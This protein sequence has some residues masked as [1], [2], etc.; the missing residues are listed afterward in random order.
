MPSTRKLP[1]VPIEPATPTVILVDVGRL[2]A[3]VELDVDAAG[4]ETSYA[5]ILG[6][7][8]RELRPG[9]RDAVPAEDGLEGLRRGE[10]RAGARV[11]LGALVV[12]LVVGGV[13][14]GGGRADLVLLDGR[15]RSGRSSP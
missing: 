12:V 2:E 6:R 8:E 4:R 3:A 5:G 13:A 14:G 11:D 9:R 7:S 1:R 15:R 10:V